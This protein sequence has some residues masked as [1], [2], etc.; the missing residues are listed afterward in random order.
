ME[1]K[2]EK[3]Q[4]LVD[5]IDK[6]G[7]KSFLYRGQSKH[8]YGL[9][10][11]LGRYS[12]K[13]KKRGFDLD[14]KCE[15]ALSIFQSELP[16]YY[17]KQLNSEMELLAL[18]QHHGLP[19]K[20]I[21]WS[22]SPLIALYFAV[23]KSSKQDAA[24]FVLDTNKAKLNWRH[25][26]NYQQQE[27]EELDS[28]IY[29]PRHVTTRLKSQQ[30]VFTY[31]KDYS[32]DQGDLEFITKYIIPGKYVNSI[33]FQLLCLGITEKVVYSD[34]DGFCRDLKFSHFHGF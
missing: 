3:V 16:E 20:L 22:L 6:I 10:P 14:S 29:M 19:T 21:D 4:D 7:Q 13:A 24:L 23:E 11:S 9:T 33:R 8:E 32:K 18:A 27:A 26:R 2:I 31:H 28:F 30:G 12:D 1:N 5:L 25:D 15:H 17:G 34:L